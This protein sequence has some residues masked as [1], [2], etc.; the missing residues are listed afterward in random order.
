MNKNEWVSFVVELKK[1]YRKKGY[2]SEEEKDI[3]DKNKK[4]AIDKGFITSKD[5]VYG[6][7]RRIKSRINV[8]SNSFSFTP[9]YKIVSPTVTEDGEFKISNP[10]NTLLSISLIWKSDTNITS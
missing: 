7:L 1:E 6:L 3:L 4:I 8:E 5:E 9:S 10:A 2:L